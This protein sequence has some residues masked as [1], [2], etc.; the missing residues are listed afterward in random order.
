MNLTIAYYNN[1]TIIIISMILHI[2][3]LL[4]QLI[5]ASKSRFAASSKQALGGDVGR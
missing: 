5:R 3:S 4:P 2:V 1:N